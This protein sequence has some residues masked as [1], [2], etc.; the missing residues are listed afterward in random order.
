MMACINGGGTLDEM[1]AVIVFNMLHGKFPDLVGFVVRD[2]LL[3]VCE[4]GGVLGAARMTVCDKNT[5]REFTNMGKLFQEYCI[6]EELK[7]MYGE[8]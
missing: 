5:G 1:L 4:S 3:Y 2:D 7:R 8:E 6:K